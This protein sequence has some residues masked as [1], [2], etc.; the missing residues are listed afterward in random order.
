[1][2]SYTG[3]VITASY[4]AQLWLVFTWHI[5][6]LKGGG[7]EEYNYLAQIFKQPKTVLL[8]MTWL[9]W[10][11]GAVFKQV[12][13]GRTSHDHWAGTRLTFYLPFLGLEG[14]WIPGWLNLLSIYIAL[15]LTEKRKK[16]WLALL[17]SLKAIIQD[18]PFKSAV[19]L[20]QK[21][22]KWISRG[23]FEA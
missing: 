8:K 9:S 11:S 23:S 17:T 14:V 22:A 12:Q 7:Q 18:K 16:D 13:T 2:R 6:P 4:M 15:V 20:T 21:P 10:G 1:M 3:K 19:L 5:S